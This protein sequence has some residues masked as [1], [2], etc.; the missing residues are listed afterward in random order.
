MDGG[1]LS[2]A[3]SSNLGSKKE[4]SIESPSKTAILTP[5]TSPASSTG[6]PVVNNLNT[7]ASTPQTSMASSTTKRI[8]ATPHTVLANP[9]T[10]AMFTFSAGLSN[11]SSKSKDSPVPSIELPGSLPAGSQ[12][13]AAPRTLPVPGPD[14]GSPDTLKE[15]NR[16][17]PEHENTTF[18]FGERSEPSPFTFRKMHNATPEPSQ[19]AEQRTYRSGAAELPD[20]SSIQQLAKKLASSDLNGTSASM[21]SNSGTSHLMPGSSTARERT[22]HSRYDVKD[23]RP[24]NEPYFNEQFQKALQKGKQIAGRIRDTLQACELAEDRE[25]HVYSMIETATELHSF[26]APAVCTIGIVGDSGVGK[27]RSYLHSNLSN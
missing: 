7:T 24:P 13:G 26:D 23:E 19:T 12:N 2:Q 6:T 14:L 9:P 27:A 8:I 10:S 15:A 17:P 3:F 18:R 20:D 5:S 16:S 21:S 22:A 4:S 11:P 25:S 1:T